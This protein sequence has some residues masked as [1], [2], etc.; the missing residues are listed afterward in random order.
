MIDKLFQISVDFAFS[1]GGKL[2][3]FLIENLCKHYA[4]LPVQFTFTSL[5]QKMTKTFQ[6]VLFVSS[7]SLSLFL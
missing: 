6:V 4:Y 5:L 1:K 3:N 7:R 2:Y